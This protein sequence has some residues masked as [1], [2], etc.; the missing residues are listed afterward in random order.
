MNTPASPT[1]QPPAA[2]GGNAL[3]RYGPP[4]AIVGIAIVV[5]AVL[6]WPK[7]DSKSTTPT[8]APTTAAAATSAPG[9]TDATG[10]TTAT[11]DASGSTTIPVDTT[12][13]LTYAKAKAMG[14]ADTIDWGARCDTKVGRDAYPSAYAQP[15]VAPFKGD[16]GG[17]TG[18]GVTADSIKVV[19]YQGQEDDPVFQF[20]AGAVNSKDTNE[21][22]RDTTNKV[23]AMWDHFTELYGRK[24]DLVYYTATGL[25]NDEVAARADA[26]AIA[27]MNPFLVTGGPAFAG[28]PFAE[29]LAA[30]KVTCLCTGGGTIDFVKERDPY[31]VSLDP[32]SQQGRVHLVEFIGKRLQGNAIYSE[33]FKDVPRK[34]GLVYLQTS[35]FS[36]AVAD[37]FK[38][39]LRDQYKIDIADMVPYTIDPATLQEQAATIIARLKSEGVTTVAFTGDPVAPISLTKEATT[40]NYFPEWVVTGSGYTETTA[41]AR[42]YDQAQWKHAFGVSWAPVPVDRKIAGSTYRYQWYYGEAP[43]APDS[44]G[45]IEA[46]IATIYYWTQAA[47]PNLSSRTFLDAMFN[48]PYVKSDPITAVRISWGKKGIWPD[49]LEPDYQG[50]DDQAEVWWDPTAKGVDEL[51]RDGVGM[52]RWV[53]GGK[54]YLP[55]DR[56]N[57]PAP[58]FVQDGSVAMLDAFPKGEELPVY[59]SPNK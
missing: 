40:Q 4:A 30:Q 38:N 41:F 19:V 43:A 18:K 34:V 56:P 48:A 25:S 17:A 3:R 5:G 12:P 52:W 8:S 28:K 27:Q 55:G 36:G 33:A 22:R 21:Q 57:G 16:N 44:I 46:S 2:G 47:G 59:P 50:L 7:S 58:F 9:S 51:G 20:I 39:T 29:E 45:G 23:S 10:T 49:S 54:R 15:C 26:Q 14:I 53:N 31:L 11:S 6:L 13:P 1:P 32:S 24:I 37:E 42:T 35:D